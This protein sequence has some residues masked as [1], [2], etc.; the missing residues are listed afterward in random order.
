MGLNKNVLW[1][2]WN[3][4]TKYLK[5]VPTSMHRLIFNN[6][7]WI[8][9]FCLLGGLMDTQISHLHTQ[10]R[11]LLPYW[12]FCLHNFAKIANLS[13]VVFLLMVL[14]HKLPTL[15]VNLKKRQFTKKNAKNFKFWEH[16]HFDISKTFQRDDD[17]KSEWYSEGLRVS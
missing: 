17:E 10:G 13:C 3:M 6:W 11:I 9:I 8:K 4:V 5:E 7:R 12:S 16:P 2:L 15:W 1:F 14:I